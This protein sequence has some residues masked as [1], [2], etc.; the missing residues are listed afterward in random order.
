M[1]LMNARSQ[2]GSVIKKGRLELMHHRRCYFDDHRGMREALN[3]TDAQGNGI[4]VRS[5]YYLHIFNRYM[6]G[7][8]QRI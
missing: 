1:T 7:S 4:K 5:L 3:E 6:E 2:G 8:I